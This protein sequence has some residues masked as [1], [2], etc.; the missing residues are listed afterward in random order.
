MLHPAR[1]RGLPVIVSHQV[2]NRSSRLIRWAR[3]VRE[4]WCSRR[5]VRLLRR[6]AHIPVRLPVVL[7]TAAVAVVCCLAAGATPLSGAASAG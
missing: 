5:T 2:Q 4:V 6:L 1:Q 3:R 7:L